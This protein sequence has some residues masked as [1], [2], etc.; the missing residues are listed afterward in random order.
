MKAEDCAR[1]LRWRWPDA[2]DWSARF[3]ALPFVSVPLRLLILRSRGHRFDPLVR[4]WSGTL[5]TGHSLSIERDT[6]VNRNCYI[7]A[8]AAVELGRQVHLG[9]GVTILTTTH[10]VGPADRRA[11]PLKVEPVRVGNGAW[12]GAN[13][14]LLPGAR[15]GAG[16]VIGAGAVVV[17]QV[18]DGETWGGVPAR[19][20]S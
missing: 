20:I 13:A 2:G 19:R 6:F 4:I 1:I 5:V 10:A 12:I 8:E 18:P 9:T 17:G 14:T 3:A 7:E 15:V 11:G 16:A